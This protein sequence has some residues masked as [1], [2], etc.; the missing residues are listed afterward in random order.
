MCVG[1]CVMCVGWC[2]VCWCPPFVCAVLRCSVWCSFLFLFL[3]AGG[4]L[5]KTRTQYQGVLGKNLLAEFGG[6]GPGKR[7]LRRFGTLQKKIVQKYALAATFWAKNN[8][9]IFSTNFARNS[10]FS[11]GIAGSGFS[12]RQECPKQISKIRFTIFR[13]RCPSF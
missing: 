11:V 12:A 6:F 5:F 7:F 4:V 2:G 1:W 13:Q 9:L 8:C 10:I 3:R